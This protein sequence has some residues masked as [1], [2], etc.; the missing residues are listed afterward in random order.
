MLAGI[1]RRTEKLTRDVLRRSEDKW[2][3]VAQGARDV[4]QEARRTRG[5]SL[6]LR[7]LPPGEP[8]TKWLGYLQQSQAGAGTPWLQAWPRRWSKDRY[9]EPYDFVPFRGT[10]Y[11]LVNRH[12][13]AVS[14]RIAG[15]EMVLGVALDFV[16]SGALG[17]V[18]FD[19]LY[20]QPM[21][22][23]DRLAEQRQAWDGLQKNQAAW[24]QFI[25]DDARAQPIRAEM[26]E[27]QLSPEAARESALRLSNLY[28]GT[29]RYLAGNYAELSAR[30]LNEENEELLL[31]NPLY[32]ETKALV[33]DGVPRGA[34][35]RFVRGRT[36][37]AID[38]IPPE[39]IDALLGVQSQLLL[40]YGALDLLRKGGPAV[41]ALR[42][43]KAHGNGDAIKGESPLGRAMTELLG[44]DSPES[45]PPESWRAF[46]AAVAETTSSIESDP[47]YRQL[48]ELRRQGKLSDARLYR[49]LQED[50]FF[51]EQFAIWATLGVE[52][53]AQD[54]GQLTE[55]ALT[56]DDLRQ[57]ALQ[58][59]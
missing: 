14:K 54:K 6:I 27:A 46:V 3:A 44:V 33:L 55:R 42:A 43:I 24:D 49:L 8:K 36:P 32:A 59:L 11:N 16:V 18:A 15:K 56:L 28:K 29:Y 45:L 58:E 38:T 51:Q 10:Y 9:G 26:K 47:F 50:Q 40:R 2:R 20:Q 35:Y 37:A 22:Q 5:R 25:R 13:R 39:K 1:F 34:P 48:S 17:W 21:A 19:Q 4:A 41:E 31:G 7:D 12:V 57:E 23:L 53:L 30:R 52:R